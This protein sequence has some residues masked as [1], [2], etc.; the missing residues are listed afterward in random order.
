MI[1]SN[2]VAAPGAHND[3]L[4]LGFILTDGAASA[5]STNHIELPAAADS[6]PASQPEQDVWM[7]GLTFSAPGRE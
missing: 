5:W 6:V 1:T 4:D 2:S 3:K 7:Q